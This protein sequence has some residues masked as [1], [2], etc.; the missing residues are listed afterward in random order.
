MVVAQLDAYR[1]LSDE[2]RARVAAAVTV[3]FTRLGRVDDEALE[4]FVRIVVPQVLAGQLR[5]SALTDAYLAA[6][7]AEVLGGPPV[8]VGVPADAIDYRQLRNGT[9]PEIVYTRP[10]ITARKALKD[11][12]DIGQALQVGAARLDGTVQ[13][14]L[15]LAERRAAHEVVR[16]DDRISGFR[17]VLRPA[18]SKSGSCGL[19]LAASSQRYGKEDLLPIHNRCHCAVM[20]IFGRR[21][22]GLRVNQERYQEASRLARDEGQRGAATRRQLANVRVRDHG[23]LGPVLTKRGDRFTGP[24]EA[25]AG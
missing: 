14:D 2:T 13:A 5:L 8:P 4:T 18:A 6:V 20:P 19:C 23:E 10:M 1:R 12:A 9:P 24:G 7:T 22:E 11:G 21:D 3:A 17:R 15:Q 16:A 25:Q